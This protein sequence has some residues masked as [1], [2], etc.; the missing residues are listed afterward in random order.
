MLDWTML[1]ERSKYCNC[2][3]FVM[4][5]ESEPDSAFEPKLRT[6]KRESYR[7]KRKWFEPTLQNC[8]VTEAKRAC[9]YWESWSDVLHP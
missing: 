7:K 8:C 9:R 6:L 5:A 3:S 4:L 2:D 1:E